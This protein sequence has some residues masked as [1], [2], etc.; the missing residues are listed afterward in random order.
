MSPFEILLILANRVLI[1]PTAFIKELTIAKAQGLAINE[2]TLGVDFRC[3][4]IMPWH[5]KQDGAKEV[6]PG[7]IGTT[8]KGIGPAYSDAYARTGIRICDL[9]SLHFGSKLREMCD[10][11]NEDYDTLVAVLKQFRHEIQPFVC[12]VSKEV[13]HAIDTNQRVLLKALKQ[14]FSTFVS[15]LTRS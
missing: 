5:I 13:N 8:K 1:E 7:A 6:Q 14:L 11:K 3:Q 12:D 15:E 4:L 2:K 10:E 9:L